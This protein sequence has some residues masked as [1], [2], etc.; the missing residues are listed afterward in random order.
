MQADNCLVKM[1]RA[2]AAEEA[3]AR[4]VYSLRRDMEQALKCVMCE[5]RTAAF[6]IDCGHGICNDD[7]CVSRRADRCSLCSCPIWSR[8]TLFFLGGIQDTGGVVLGP[9]PVTP[10]D[11]SLSELRQRL[12]GLQEELAAADAKRH[13]DS[14]EDLEGG[15][16]LGNGLVLLFLATYCFLQVP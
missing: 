14:Q 5:A 2:K 1:T 9:S 10:R 4:K 3:C 7:G 8:T 6:V 12:V 16:K 11:P 15:Q 13:Q